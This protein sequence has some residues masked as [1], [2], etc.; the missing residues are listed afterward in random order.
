MKIESSAFTRA[1]LD[2][3]SDQLLEHE[4]LVLADR[5]ERASARLA[6]LGPRIQAGHGSGEWSA[7]EVLA[8]IS[9]LS[10][11]YGVLT[12]KISSGQLTEL[13]ILGN[14]HLRDVLGEKLAE[15]PPAEL[16]EMA[17]KDQARALQV[18]RSTDAPSLRREAKLED[19]RSMSAESVA[20]YALVNHLETH[21]DQ[22]QQ[23]LG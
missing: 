18:L 15:I 8:H 19:G 14:V 12:Y 22:L 11:F 17:L 2:A 16:L 13:D 3:F 4:R 23:A 10:K 9:V 20:R 5:L 21:V 6:A 1:D 7:H